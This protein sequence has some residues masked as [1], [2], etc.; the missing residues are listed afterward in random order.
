MVLGPCPP[1]AGIPE[2]TRTL[3][4]WRHV[5]R[6]GAAGKTELV[7]RR[8]GQG[9]RPHS[10]GDIRVK[11][12]RNADVWGS[13]LQTRKQLEQRPCGRSRPGTARGQHGGQAKGRGGNT[14][15][16]T[17]RRSENTGEQD[18]AMAGPG[19]LP[20]PRSGADHLAKAPFPPL[21]FPEGEGWGLRDNARDKGLGPGG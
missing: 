19:D 15:E 21:A 20:L 9:L 10:E 2:W 14:G 8:A 13:T 12:G 7:P 18:R 3:C 1:A 4:S 6:D 5:G 17:E 16:G 11:W